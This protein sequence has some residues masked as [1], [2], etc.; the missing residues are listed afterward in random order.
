MGEHH[1]LV[2]AD[3]ES[4]V[5]GNPRK[6]SYELDKVID[7]IV[8]DDRADLELL[9]SFRFGAILASQ[10]PQCCLLR[11]LVSCLESPEVTSQHSRKV[12]T[13]E[14]VDQRLQSLL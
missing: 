7:V 9:P 1:H 12:E 11:F 8:I 13:A 6:L 3:N 2:N 5:S 4:L 10:P 14:Q